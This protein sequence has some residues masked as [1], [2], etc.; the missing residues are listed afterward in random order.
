MN[1]QQLC[2]CRLQTPLTE[3]DEKRLGGWS[4]LSRPKNLFSL[5]EKFLLASDWLRMYAIDADDEKLSP[6]RRH[7]Q[8]SWKTDRYFDSRS[9][10]RALSAY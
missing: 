8:Q 9:E 5:A 1:I 7:Q 4:I 2:L 3:L 10:S 6:C